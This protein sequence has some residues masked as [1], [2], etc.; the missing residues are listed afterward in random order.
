VLQGRRFLNDFFPFGFD[1]VPET[2][3]AFKE[4]AR[5]LRV[6]G[7]MFF[8]SLWLKKNSESMRLAEKHHVCEVASLTKLENALKKAGLV[9]DLVEEVYSGVWSH[10]PMDLLPVEGDEYKHVIVQAKK[11]AG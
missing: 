5:I 11:P 6:D 7:R 4:C 10:N 2:V 8:S 3:L 9:L 1:S